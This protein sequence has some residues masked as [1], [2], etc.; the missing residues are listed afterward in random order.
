MV[1]LEENLKM[2]IHLDVKLSLWNAIKIRIAG[3]KEL[4][5]KGLLMKK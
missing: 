3:F 5:F 4:D 1:K 2:T